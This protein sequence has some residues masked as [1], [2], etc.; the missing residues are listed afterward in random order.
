MKFY[1]LF[2][3]TII[4]SACGNLNKTTQEVNTTSTT[5]T[6]SEESI[7]AHI[8][9]LA[10]DELAGRDIGTEGIDLAATYLSNQFESYG[11]KPFFNHYRDS[12]KIQENNAYNVVGFLEGTDVKLKEEIFVIGAHYDHIGF[13]GQGITSEDSIANGANDNASGVSAVLEL[14]QYFALNPPKRSVLFVLF[15][16]EEVGL[17]G[18]K[19][20]AKRFKDSDQPLYAVF[21][22]EMVGVPLQKQN[23]S[24]YMTGYKISSFAKRFNHYAGNKALGYFPKAAEFDLFR[25]SD[26]YPFYTELNIPA[27]TIC[28]FDFTNF[29]YYHHVKD[30]RSTIDIAHMKSLITELSVGLSGLLNEKESSIKFTK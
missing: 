27:Q 11:I 17:L 6:F 25:R 24:A 8:D 12:F 15:S 9:Y 14:A 19:H 28:T 18:S 22:I 1:A 16:A 7:I 2:I 4:L 13:K 21:N 5:Y 30:E 10:S 26:N 20:L 29:D 3:G 23:Y